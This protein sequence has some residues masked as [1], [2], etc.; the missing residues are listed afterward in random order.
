M[1]GV[2]IVYGVQSSINAGLVR[3]DEEHEMCLKPLQPVN[4]SW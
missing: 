4:D 3:Y 2:E 1:K